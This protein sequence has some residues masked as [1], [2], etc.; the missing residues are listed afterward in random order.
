MAKVILDLDSFKAL[1]SDTR[2]DILKALD[3][4]NMGLNDL[5]RETQLT[6]ATLHE[7]LNK[8][9]QAGLIKKNQRDGHK[10]VYY[11]LSWK[12]SS[13]LHPENTRV[14]LLFTSTIIA[15]AAAITGFFLYL[16]QLVPAETRNEGMFLTQEDS[17]SKIPPLLEGG[18]EVITQSQLF[19]GIGVVCTII[20]VTFLCISLWRYKKNK[21]QK[22]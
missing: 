21:E 6:K 20:F 7:H 22:L 2:V 11:K 15:L 5:C 9:I 1:S 4:K 12:G 10:W 16:K 17:S 13:L 14:M 3:G 8:L 18:R 19:L